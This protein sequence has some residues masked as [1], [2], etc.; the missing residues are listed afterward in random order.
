MASSPSGTRSCRAS[1]SYR[2]ALPKQ[3][4]PTRPASTRKS[5]SASA[6]SR[7]SCRLLRRTARSRAGAAAGRHPHR[8]PRGP[9]GPDRREPSRARVS[10]RRSAPPPR[11]AT[12]RWRR[13]PRSKPG[14]EQLRARANEDASAEYQQLAEQRE[15]AEARAHA[16]ESDLARLREQADAALQAAATEKDSEAA[17]AAE[18]QPSSSSCAAARPRTRRR[19]F[20]SSP[21]SGRRPRRAPRRSTP[22]SSPCREQ[23]AG[24]DEGLATQVSGLTDALQALTVER[25]AALERAGSLEPRWSRSATSCGTPFPASRSTAPRRTSPICAASSPR[26]SGASPRASA[27]LRSEPRAPRPAPARRAAV[28]ARG[29]DDFS[30]RAERD[31]QPRALRARGNSG[32]T[33]LERD[34]VAPE[35]GDIVEVDGD[36]YVVRR[37]GPSPLP[38]PGAAAPTSS[39]PDAFARRACAPASARPLF[40]PARPRG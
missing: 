21:S 14:A 8:R 30:A 27:R 11:A 6:R 39:G 31:R 2:R 38:A 17:R 18:S 1:T 26:A 7:A 3:R 33:L 9:P 32:Y 23:A 25:D 28:P 40:R 19:S 24:Q 16:L 34:G 22:S 35:A 20:R 36:R 5:R 12:R 37:H 29:D 15:A 10:W 4:R 13:P